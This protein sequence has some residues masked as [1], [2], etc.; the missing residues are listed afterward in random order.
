MFGKDI[1]TYIILWTNEIIKL[2]LVIVLM[3]YL[4]KEKEKKRNG[5]F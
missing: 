5:R 4:P 2:A 1:Q 3:Y